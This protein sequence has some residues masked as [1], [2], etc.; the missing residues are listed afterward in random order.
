MVKIYLKDPA[1]IESQYL[2][3]VQKELSQ[4]LFALRESL[5]HLSGSTVN[6]A[7][8]GYEKSRRLTEKLVNEIEGHPIYP[9]DDYK[10]IAYQTTLSRYISASTKLSGINF[11]NLYKL[12]NDLLSRNELLLAELLTAPPTDLQTKNSKLGWGTFGAFEI[13]VIKLLFN[14]DAQKAYWELIRDFFKTKVPITFCPYCNFDMVED[15]PSTSG[16]AYT[17]ALDHFYSQSEFPLLCFSFYNLIPAD[18]NCNSYKKH[19]KTF[20]D[21]F[22]LHPYLYDYGQNASFRAE[23]LPPF[24]KVTKIELNVNEVFGKPMYK[25]MLG[26]RAV[27]TPGH[28]LGNINVFKINE[29]YQG[30]H[31]LETAKDTLDALRNMTSLEG[32]LKKLTDLFII[33]GEKRKN[34][35]KSWY[36]KKLRSPFSKIDFCNKPFSKLN[37]DLHD[38]HILKS[39]FLQSYIGKL[40]D[41]DNKLP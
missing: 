13:F 2:S 12:L 41:D 18:T 24:E 38:H 3:S 23:F 19:T 30:T 20:S 34:A 33:D 6:T 15:V 11:S 32:N 28:K 36:R 37:R 26:D 7:S 39:R 31:F 4:R 14:T 16:S 29:L 9:K 21:D 40:I 17:S 8:T 35:Y 5:D 10:S 25:R 1:K 27:Y 22:H